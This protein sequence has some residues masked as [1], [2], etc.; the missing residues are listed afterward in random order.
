MTKNLNKYREIKERDDKE[1]M[2]GFGVYVE[3][4]ALSHAKLQEALDRKTKENIELRNPLPPVRKSLD[5]DAL[6]S[7]RTTMK[8]VVRIRI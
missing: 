5:P 8:K 3:T 4:L 2:G 7:H 1:T 6:M